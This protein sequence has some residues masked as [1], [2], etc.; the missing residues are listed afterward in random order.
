MTLNVILINKSGSCEEIIL[1]P[2]DT[3]CEEGGGE[4]SV[5]PYIM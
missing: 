1:V 4:R 5:V 3:R 2:L